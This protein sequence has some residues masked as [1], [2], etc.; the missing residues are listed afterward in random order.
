MLS[1]QTQLANAL[2]VSVWRN[3]NKQLILHALVDLELRVISEILP[4]G[5]LG[6]ITWSPR[7]IRKHVCGKVFDNSVKYHAITAH[8]SKWRISVQLSQ[9]MIMG[10]IRVQTD[11][12]PLVTLRHVTDLLDYLW[13]DAGAL[14]HIDA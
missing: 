8:T 10:V 4:D 5:S 11:Q 3:S 6:V 9:N 1:S 14:N 7:T 12:N 13:R 2:Q